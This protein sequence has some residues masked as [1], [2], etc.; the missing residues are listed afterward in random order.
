MILQLGGT[1]ELSSALFALERASIFVS[2]DVV[3]QVSLGD[4]FLVA[5]GALMVPLSIVTASVNLQV[6]VLCEPFPA[7]VALKGLHSLVLP[8][9]DVQT[10]F[11]RISTATNLAGERLLCSVVEHVGLQMSFRD[12]GHLAVLM[13]ARVWS[14]SS[15]LVNH[16][17]RLHGCEYGSS[18]YHF[19]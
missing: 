18:S 19:I 10:R 13:R 4:E 1:I 11:L 17:I 14:F 8:Y 7:D 9:V 15:L 16:I 12:E 6:P 2:L 3:L 5:V